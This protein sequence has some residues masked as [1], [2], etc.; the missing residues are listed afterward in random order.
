MKIQD[1]LAGSMPHDE[2]RGFSGRFDVVGDIAI[3]T[4]P[5]ALQKYDH[6][7]ADAIL[8]HRHGIRTVVNKSSH[9]TGDFRTA[10]YKVIVGNDMVTTHREFGFSYHLDLTTSF[11]NPR[12]A[13]ERMRV[14]GQVQSGEN[15]IVPFCGVGPFAIPAAARDASVVAIEQNPDAFHWL[16]ENIRE[17]EVVGK[18]A[19]I[20][21]DAFNPEILPAG[22]FDRA[23]IPTPYGWDH[24][25]DVIA[26]RV[27]SGGIIHFY[28]F[29][30]R[31]QSEILK[32][33]FVKRRYRVLIRRRCGN[34]APA[35]SRWV[36][37]LQVP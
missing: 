13:Q 2:L 22:L 37:D 36:F 11:F 18:I 27:K 12:L 30:N 24:I 19:A 16:K 32:N 31:A 20:R 25:L 28:T 9:I 8:K 5:P 3:L 6:V 15:V 23:I 21:G 34:V 26:P 10:H 29:K 4:I 17:N 33:E 35:V 14:T 1:A 7:I